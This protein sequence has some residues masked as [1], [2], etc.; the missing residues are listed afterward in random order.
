MN[1]NFSDILNKVNE[2][3]T[4]KLSVAAANDDEVIEAVAMAHDRKIADSILVGDKVQI[5]KI[6]QDLK[7]DPSIFEIIDIKDPIEAA[8]EAVKLVHDGE[9]DM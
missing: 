2:F 1:K 3:P 8:Q 6:C 7:V 5:E 9:A 4:K